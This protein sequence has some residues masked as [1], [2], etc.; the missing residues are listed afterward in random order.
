MPKTTCVEMSQQEQ[1]QMLAALRRTRYGYL[2]ALHILL[3]YAM[4]R[5][6]TGIAAVLFCSRASVYWIVHAYQAGILG[7]RPEKDGR[8]SPPRRT[9]VL[10][11]TVRRSL[12]ALLDARGRLGVERRQS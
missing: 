3:L 8:L 2:L 7:L 5:H 6:P 1:A 12:V 9:T 10:V 4:G 11:P